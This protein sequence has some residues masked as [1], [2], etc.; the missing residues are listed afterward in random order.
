MAIVYF[1]K[2]RNRLAAEFMIEENRA[3]N[4]ERALAGFLSGKSISPQTKGSCHG[5]INWLPSEEF[6]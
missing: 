3:N 5:H 1:S 2:A 4:V 6:G